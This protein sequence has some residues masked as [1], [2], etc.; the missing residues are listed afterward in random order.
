MNRDR[1]QEQAPNFRHNGQ[2]HLVR[3]FVCQGARGRENYAAAIATGVC[4]WCGWKEDDREHRMAPETGE[5]PSGQGE[6][7]ETQGGV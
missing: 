2:L 5:V 7:K 1:N 4:A 3:C 6:E